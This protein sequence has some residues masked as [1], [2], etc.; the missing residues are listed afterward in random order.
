MIFSVLGVLSAI[1]F[2]LGDLP[3]VYDTIT[4][5][6]K[7]QRITWGVVF[8]LNCIGFAN[9]YASGAKNSLWIFGAAVIVTGIIVILSIKNGVGGHG[10]IDVFSLF[11][12]LLGIGLWAMFDSPFLSIVANLC[13][14]T[15]ALIPTFIKA[16]KEP[17]S[18]TKITW[19]LGAI[20]AL[21]ASVSVG[22]LN[23]NLLI[24]PVAST[25]LQL[26]MAYLL[27]FGPNSRTSVN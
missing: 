15:I 14:A 1:I 2:I 21:L 27:Y 20:S 7:P 9:Q 4:G 3:Y 8:L 23:L 11:A 25:V 5:K 6:T 16:Y 13:V 24:L 26:T 18:E 19:L 17:G 22:S 12:A 10:K